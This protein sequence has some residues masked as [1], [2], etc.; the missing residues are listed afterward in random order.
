MT[1]SMNASCVINEPSIIRKYFICGIFF[2]LAQLVLAAE[3]N[4]GY[5]SVG[6]ATGASTL[7]IRLS[8]CRSVVVISS[9]LS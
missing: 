9:I 2:A 1:K 7:S 4:G 5:L 8:V 6:M 3:K